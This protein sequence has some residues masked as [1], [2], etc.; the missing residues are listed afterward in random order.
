MTTGDKIKEMEGKL[1]EAGVPV[2]ALCASANIRRSTWTRWKAGVNSPNL[3]T[4]DRVS[5]AFGRLVSDEVA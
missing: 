4:W 5:T 1:R 3:T 2:D